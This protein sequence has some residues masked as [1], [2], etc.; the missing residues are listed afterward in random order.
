MQCHEVEYQWY[1]QTLEYFLYGNKNVSGKAVLVSNSAYIKS[2]L[3]DTLVACIPVLTCI[4]N[5]VYVSLFFT[6]KIPI[7]K[8]TC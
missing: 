5:Y 7:C 6:L 4:Y 3:S 2:L 8:F 1:R